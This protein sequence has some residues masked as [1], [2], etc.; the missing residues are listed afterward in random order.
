[1][2][3]QTTRQLTHDEDEDEEEAESEHD[4][5]PAGAGTLEAIEGAWPSG[6]CSVHIIRDDLAKKFSLLKVKANES[7][8]G[9]DIR[10]LS[11]IP[12]LRSRAAWD[13]IARHWSSMGEVNFVQA[14]EKSF[15]RRNSGWSDAHFAFGIPSHNNALE[16]SNRW[17]RRVVRLQVK[18]FIHA[19]PHTRKS[20]QKPPL[21]QLLDRFLA[22]DGVVAYA[23]MFDQE[24]GF[25]LEPEISWHLFNALHL[26]R[27]NRN[28]AMLYQVA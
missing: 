8:I 4:A 2:K 16:S 28:L 26:A 22:S 23:S 3:T 17:V 6:A 21:D 1:M 24:K 15:I 19:T 5:E 14:F 13:A 11:V 7:I 27:I 18:K 9:R 10:R 12:P 20:M 25:E